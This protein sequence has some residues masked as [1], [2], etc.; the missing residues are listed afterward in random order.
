MIC[1]PVQNLLDEFRFKHVQNTFERV[2]AIPKP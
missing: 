2:Q 1:K